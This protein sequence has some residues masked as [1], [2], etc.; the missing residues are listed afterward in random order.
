M[1]KIERQ[2]QKIFS[3]EASSDSLA[4]FGSMITG[5]PV[6]TD[7][8]DALQSESYEKG[9]EAAIAANEAPFL[10][11]MNGVQ[12]GF[13][14][15]IAYLLQEGVAEYDAETTYFK[16]SWCRIGQIFYQ[17]LADENVGNDPTTSTTNWKAWQ[18]IDLASDEEASIGESTTTAVTPKQLQE[19]INNAIIGA[20]QYRGSWEASGQT[21]YSSIELPVK[22]GYVYYVEGSATIGDI[23]WETGDFLLINSDVAVGQSITDVK[24]LDHT[25]GGSGGGYEFLD[26]VWRPFPTEEAGK[27]L[28]DGSLLQYGSYRAAIDKIAQL[29]EKYPQGFT[30]ESDWQSTVA[31][32]GSCGKFVYDPDAKTVRLPKISDIMQCTTDLNALG[33]LVQSGLPSHTHTRGTMEILGSLAYIS[34]NAINSLPANSSSGA[35]SWQTNNQQVGRGTANGYGYDIAF[36]A[37]NGWTGSTSAPSYSSTTASTTKVQPQTI[38]GLIYIVI[39]TS[40]KTDVEIDINEVMLDVN[41]KADK[42]LTNISDTG[43]T[44]ISNLGMPGTK[45]TP[46]TAGATGS[47]YKAPADGYFYAYVI[48]GVVNNMVQLAFNSSLTA[49]CGSSMNSN[50]GVILPV[51]KGSSVI[52]RYVGT[53]VKFGFY[54]AKGSESEA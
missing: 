49:E 35:L 18:F 1:S 38:K 28:A 25:F 47:S 4:V 32:Y 31:T 16:N 37:S 19:N 27:V 40:V 43:K 54:Y 33:D 7:S 30:T 10:E 39:G 29:Y 5:N 21:D 44:L 36:K 53:L 11:E 13:S 17:S 22:A 52:L 8:L 46:L 51:A 23:E 12:Y 9:W 26:Y 41:A 24:Q 34:S 45:V 3:G 14:K 15:Q 20:L 50:N 42:D 2:T 6:Y 48:G